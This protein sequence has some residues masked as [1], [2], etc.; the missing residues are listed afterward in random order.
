[1]DFPISYAP[2]D[3]LFGTYARFFIRTIHGFKVVTGTKRIFLHPKGHPINKVEIFGFVTNKI[4]KQNSLKLSV[5]D[6][7]GSIICFVNKPIKSFG[8]QK[9][10]AEF[11]EAMVKSDFA[12]NSTLLDSKL[13]C[14]DPGYNMKTGDF[15]L[16]RA[17]LLSSNWN[18]LPQII[19]R[20]V[21]VV[22]EPI[23]EKWSKWINETITL[24]EEVYSRVFDHRSTVDSVTCHSNNDY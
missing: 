9:T 2:L 6:G 8:S 7:T 4:D 14:R 22:E 5:D 12:R 23:L 19:A 15:I 13:I 21:E 17:D 1:M 18:P 24:N 16:V 11:T 3:P 10:V 20:Q